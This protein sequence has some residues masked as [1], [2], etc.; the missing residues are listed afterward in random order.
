[1]IDDHVSAD[2]FVLKSRN[3]EIFRITHGNSAT[4][5]WPSEKDFMRYIERNY[6]TQLQAANSVQ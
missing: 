3:R 6:A 5:L 4:L 1:M 2:C